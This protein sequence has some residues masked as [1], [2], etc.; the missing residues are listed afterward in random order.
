MVEIVK[1]HSLNS[2][3]ISNIVEYSKSLLDG[4]TKELKFFTILSKM[5]LKKKK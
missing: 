2:E 5:K 4:E 1:E 3:R